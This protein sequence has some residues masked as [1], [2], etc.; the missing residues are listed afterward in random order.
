MH[1][2]FEEIHQHQIDEKQLIRKSKYI[3]CGILSKNSGR[4]IPI[5]GEVLPSQLK[6]LIQISKYF[7]KEK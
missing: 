1:L 3:V 7:H 4:T 6:T 5:S 2:H